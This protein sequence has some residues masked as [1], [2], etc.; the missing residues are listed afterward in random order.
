M[1][2]Q[3]KNITT[4]IIIISGMVFISSCK[5]NEPTPTLSTPMGALYFHIHTDID[6]TEVA[7]D[8]VGADAN[9][10]RFSMHVGEFYV[11]GITLKKSDGTSYSLS[12]N[13]YLLKTIGTEAYY[14]DSVP[15]GNYTSVSFNV[16]IDAATNSKAP[17]SFSSSS[18]LS[19]QNP[20]MWFGTTTEGYIF[21][22]VQG[23]ADTSSTHNGAVNFPIS[24]QI[25]TNALL[26]N[27]SM[28]YQTFTVVA[29]QIQYVHIIAD[30]G[31]MLNGIDFKAHNNVS[32][33]NSD[34]LT[35]TQI[36]NNIPNMFRYE[37]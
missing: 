28:P 9:G 2:N 25:G 30:Y 5:K 4:I 21:M 22:N 29:N 17:S 37:Y 15:A 13:D 1:K 3:I 12:A 10:R 31:K 18:V 34:S 26:R 14:V 33:F 16:G 11:S 27:V 19:A 6:T 36:A 32:P 7:T 23:M 8:S 35:A 24:Y 20:S